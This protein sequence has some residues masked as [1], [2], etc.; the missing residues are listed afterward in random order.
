MKVIARSFVV[1]GTVVALSSVYAQAPAPKTPAPKTPAPKGSKPG[2]LESPD[3]DTPGKTPAKGAGSNAGSAAGSGAGSG[4]TA[5]KAGTDESL[6]TGAER[7]WATGV[8]PAEQATALKMFRDG[9]IQLNDG[10]FAK[11]ADNY[12]EALKHWDHPAIHY[13]L[14]LAQANL[15][16]PVEA[17]ENIQASMKFGEAPLQSKDKFDHAKEYL[18]LLEKQLADVEVSC[19][20]TGA[21]VMIDGQQVFVAPGKYATKVKVGKHTFVGELEGHPTEVDAPFVGPGEHFRIELKL[22]TVAE[23]TRYRRRWDATWMPYAVLGGGVFVGAVS[24]L[25][26]LSATSNYADY[27]RKVQQCSMGVG[28]GTSGC[29]AT[30]SLTSIRNSGDTKRAVAFV[31]YGIAGAAVA[32][33]AVLLWLNRREAYQIRADDLK[34]SPGEEE[35]QEVMVTPIVTPT[36]AGAAVQ[37]HF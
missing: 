14:A 27:D 30:P 31:G 36:M 26:A 34:K 33:G 28:V 4:I 10:L 21:K 9:N 20:K 8:S 15:D 16:Q 25:L 1:L 17:Y 12:K 22:Y 32:T 2:D 11:A 19:L 13:N 29:D 37:G 18:V 24:S 7:P 35:E 23:L 6:N 5:E 3:G